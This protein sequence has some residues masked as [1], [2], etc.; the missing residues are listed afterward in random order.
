MDRNQGT[1]NETDMNQGRHFDDDT[2]MRE[3][4]H[5]TSSWSEKSWVG[6]FYPEGMR[7]A[8]FLTYYASRCAT[9]TG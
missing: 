9:G 6:T 2:L 8:D 4:A 5:G 7:P 3:L 1:G